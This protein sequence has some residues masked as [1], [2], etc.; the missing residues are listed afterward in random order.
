LSGYIHSYAPAEQDRLIRQGEFLAPWTLRHLDLSGRKEV[1]EVG[2]GVGAQLRVLLQRHPDSHTTG[3]DLSPLQLDRARGLLAEPIKAGRVELVEA[4]AYALPFPDDH[5]DA[6]CVF[7]LLEH[8]HDHLGVLRE[9]L[10]VLKPGG[11]LYCTEVFNAGLYA[12]PAQP[13]MNAYWAAFND[14][15]R[16]LGGDP[17]VGIRLGGLLATAGF[18]EISLEEVSPLIDGRTPDLAARRDFLDFWQTLLLSGA[19][20]LLRHGRI[21]AER[22]VGLKAAFT[23]QIGR[24]HV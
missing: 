11:V 4:S 13:A 14:L 8:L 18:S 9:I 23:A 1:L 16:E 12:S 17:D 20:E 24:A 6:C 22:V 19:A 10:R 2:C 21:D 3:V 7:W 5:F 15:Q